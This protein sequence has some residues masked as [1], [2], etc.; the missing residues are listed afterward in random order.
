MDN[1]LLNLYDLPMAM[2]IFIAVV[3]ATGLLGCS[4]TNSR[5]LMLAGYLYTIA[6]VEWDKLAFWS[7]PIHQLIEPAIPLLFTLGKFASLAPP[8]FLYLFI[9]ATQSA[10]RESAKT[11]QGFT[12]YTGGLATSLVIAGIVAVGALLSYLM[13]L[14][15]TQTTITYTAADYHHTFFNVYFQLLMWGKYALVFSVALLCINLQLRSKPNRLST[16]T[17]SELPS[18]ELT[19]I[20]I[21]AIFIYAFELTTDVLACFEVKG[22]LLNKMGIAHNYLMLSYMSMI[23]MYMLRSYAPKTTDKSKKNDARKHTRNAEELARIHKIMAEQQY[24]LD[25][26][27]T[28]EKLASVLKMPEHQLS[29]LLNKNFNIHFFD[30]INQY[31]TEHAKKLMESSNEKNYSMLSILYDSGFNSKSTFNRCFKK[32]TGITP[33]EFRGKV[34]THTN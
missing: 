21:G 2:V 26:G 24:Y 34:K 29:L 25:P 4:P 8:L 15:F 27:I 13:H 31:R 6:I 28:L 23:L 33:S 32:Y 12:K 7:N 17:R 9:H 19:T 18:Q 30:F 10:F 20:L 11:R 1:A 3:L 22:T 14:S 5:K 16:K